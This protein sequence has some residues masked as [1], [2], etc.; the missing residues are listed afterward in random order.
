LRAL[1]SEY[2]RSCFA[3]E[4]IK[5]HPQKLLIIGPKL[6]FQVLAWLPKPAQN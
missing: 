3:H 6:F 4:N 1:G 5:K 2:L